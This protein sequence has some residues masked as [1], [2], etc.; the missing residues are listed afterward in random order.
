MNLSNILRQ[1]QVTAASAVTIDV[2][3]RA[4]D[5]TTAPARDVEEARSDAISRGEYL[6]RSA[7][8]QLTVG[9]DIARELIAGGATYAG[10]PLLD[11]AKREA[12]KAPIADIDR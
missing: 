11:P 7:D 1:L 4:S 3:P 9:L 6:A 12:P 5:E 10:D 8:F 2:L